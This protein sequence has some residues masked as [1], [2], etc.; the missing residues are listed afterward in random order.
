MK[1][2]I[3]REKYLEKILPFIQKEIIKVFVGQRRVGKSY[4]MYQIIDFL[5]QQNAANHIIYINK[6]LN[7]FDSLK[8]YQQ[9]YD[10]VKSKSLTNT[11]NYLFIDEIQNISGFENA[12]KSLIAEGNYDIYCTGSNANL[13]SG[14][15]ATF[16]SGRYIEFN[17]YL[18]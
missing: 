12:L 13:L 2:Y 9:F 5:L 4:L 8:N 11:T 3:S 17:V 18:I 7:E 10:F 6:E 14:E 16:L 1:K 15:L